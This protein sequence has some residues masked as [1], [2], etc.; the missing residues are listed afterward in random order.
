MGLYAEKRSKMT[1]SYCFEQIP[2]A[3]SN[4]ETD[5]A[6][7]FII[8]SI[9]SDVQLSDRLCGRFLSSANNKLDREASISVCSEYGWILVEEGICFQEFQMMQLFDIVGFVQILAQQRPFRMT[10]KSDADEFTLSQFPTPKKLNFA[11]FNELNRIPA[12]IVGFNL[13]WTLQNCS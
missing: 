5:A 8:G 2:N 6:N 1:S 11:S 9:G 3:E 7:T 12:G 10:F 13:R 4:V